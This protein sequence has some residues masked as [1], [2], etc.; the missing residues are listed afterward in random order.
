MALTYV[1][2]ATFQF[3][4]TLADAMRRRGE[5]DRSQKHDFAIQ[6]QRISADDRRATQDRLEQGRQHDDVMGYRR[7][8]SDREQGNWL[9]DFDFRGERAR[10]GDTQWGQEHTLRVNQDR[11][12]GAAHDVALRQAGL[13]ERLQTAQ[14]EDF[15]R[16]RERAA[17]VQTYQQEFIAALQGRAPIIGPSK[18]EDGNTLPRSIQGYTQLQGG[19]EQ[20]AANLDAIMSRALEDPSMLFEMAP[21]FI[22]GMKALNEATNNPY[23]QGLFDKYSSLLSLLDPSGTEPSVLAMSKKDRRPG[24]GGGTQQAVESWLRNNPA[25]GLGDR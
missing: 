9:Q 17:E 7:A 21:S 25:A 20:W 18:D 14:I 15:F 12:A 8:E 4:H 11:R 3:G 5:Q 19:P 22:Q 13:A 10:V 16:S 2:T 6:E 24:Q 23:A 1:P